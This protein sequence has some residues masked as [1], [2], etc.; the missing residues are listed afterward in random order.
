M[1]NLITASTYKDVMGIT[2]TNSDFQIGYYVDSV[3]QLVK[4]YCNNTF[5]DHVATNKTELFSI[6]WSQTFVQL[7][8]SPVTSIVSVKER[9]GIT[10][11]YTTLTSG[12]DYYLD[13][14]TDS[15]F[16]SNGN[17]GYK[18]FPLGPGSVEVIYKAGYTD[19]S[20][21]AEVP[22]DLRLAVIDLITYYYK[23]QSKTRQTIAGASIQNNVTSSQRNNVAFPDHIKRVLDLYKNY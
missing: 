23:D 12:T 16:R 3:S 4:T 18:S 7:S 17:M 20:G 15:V 11:A 9:D 13:T 5:V 10:E 6:N 2:T 8:E 21:N 19:A 14:S 1:A 22:E